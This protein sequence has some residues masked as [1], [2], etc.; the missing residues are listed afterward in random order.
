MAENRHSSAQ[1]QYSSF[2]QTQ[3]STSGTLAKMK[4]DL[5]SKRNQWQNLP[6]LRAQRMAQLQSKLREQQLESYLE[7]STLLARTS[8]ISDQGVKPSYKAM[9]SKQQPTLNDTKFSTCRVSV[10]R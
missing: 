1:Q 4:N 9:E 6:Q 8:L 10:Q 3:L 5:L 2:I 7:G